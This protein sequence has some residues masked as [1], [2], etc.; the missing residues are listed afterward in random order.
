[1]FGLFLSQPYS[2]LH[3]THPNSS[4]PASSLL[5]SAR[6]WFTDLKK[7]YHVHHL[8]TQTLLTSSLGEVSK[9]ER[10]YR[11]ARVGE[12]QCFG[13]MNSWELFFGPIPHEEKGTSN[14]KP[15]SNTAAIAIL[16]PF[17]LL[18]GGG[19]SSSPAVGNHKWAPSWVGEP[20]GDTERRPAFHPPPH[21]I[22]FSPGR[23]SYLLPV[24][25]AERSSGPATRRAL[26]AVLGSRRPAGDPLSRTRPL[27]PMHSQPSE[28]AVGPAGERKGPCGWACDSERGHGTPG[29]SRAPRHTH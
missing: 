4:K 7:H 29:E 19:L 5:R 15:L 3:S 6:E 10:I 26:H 28:S 2:S 1:M 16:V 18:L 23:Y 20:L 14:I 9:A 13:S 11:A 8:L 24:R 27:L 17:C 25:P 21:T 12:F 22:N